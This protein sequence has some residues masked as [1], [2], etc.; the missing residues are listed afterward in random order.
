MSKKLCVVVEMNGVYRT[1]YEGDTF[2]ITFPFSDLG[3][4]IKSPPIRVEKIGG[5]DE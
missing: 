4:T 5:T 2:T 1:L 3:M